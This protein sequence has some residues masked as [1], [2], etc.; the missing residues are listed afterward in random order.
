[1]SAPEH[2]IRAVRARQD[3]SESESEEQEVSE[4]ANPVPVAGLAAGRPLLDPSY[5]DEVIDVEIEKRRARL[6]D[7]AGGRIAT[8]DPRRAM[9]VQHLQQAG[10]IGPDQRAD[11]K[12]DLAK[13]AKSE[14]VSVKADKDALGQHLLERTGRAAPNRPE[15]V[16]SDIDTL[17]AGRRVSKNVPNLG[18]EHEFTKRLRQRQQRGPDFDPTKHLEAERKKREDEAA[19]EAAKKKVDDKLA[20]LS[21]VVKVAR[22]ETGTPYES[23]DLVEFDLLAAKEDWTEALAALDRLE[24]ASK[25]AMG[26]VKDAVDGLKALREKVAKAPTCHKPTDLQDLGQRMNDAYK[27]QRWLTVERE[28]NAWRARLEQAAG[29]IDRVAEVRRRT[30]LLKHATQIDNMKKFLAKHEEMDWQTVVD[31]QHDTHREGSLAYLEDRLKRYEGNTAAAEAAELARRE[32]VENGLIAGNGTEIERKEVDKFAGEERVAIDNAV[33][34]YDAGTAPVLTHPNGMKWAEPY[35]N[36][37]GSLPGAAGAG[38]YKEYYVEKKPGSTTYHGNRR[39][40]VHNKKKW[41]YYTW[42]H[43]GDNGKPNFVRLR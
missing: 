12:A 14:A 10:R 1:M 40:V 7:A 8:G 11:T 41:M 19:K 5:E 29:F 21:K 4:L 34:A 43:Y 38:G 23:A 16:Q 18:P 3:A 6:S 15:S 28:F 20:Q 39:L 27:A 17:N 2:L 26:N 31:T 9:L 42:T 32:K 37:D 30:D 33:T 13:L 22:A 36:R 25:A 24:A 35:G